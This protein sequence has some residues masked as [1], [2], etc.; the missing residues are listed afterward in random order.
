M[1]YFAYRS[2]VSDPLGLISPI[3]LQPKLIFQELCRNKLEW[4]EVINDRNIINKLTKIFHDLGQFHLINAPRH[5]FC[6]KG[7]DIEFHEFSD[8]SGK[9]YGVCVFVQVS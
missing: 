1:Q 9:S 5:G 3:M 7:R 4:D 8:S 2:Y 6:C